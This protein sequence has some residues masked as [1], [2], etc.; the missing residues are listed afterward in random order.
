MMA[1]AVS[2]ECPN[3]AASVH[4]PH[5]EFFGA[6]DYPPPSV[7]FIGHLYQRVGPYD[8]LMENKDLAQNHPAGL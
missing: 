8:L 1:G 4:D 2:R 7:G 6:M 3:Q 5:I